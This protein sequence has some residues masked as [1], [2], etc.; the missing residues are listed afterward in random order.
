MPGDVERFGNE[1]QNPLGHHLPAQ[2]LFGHRIGNQEIAARKAE[3]QRA[4]GRQPRGL[5]REPLLDR[6]ERGI[7]HRRAIGRV[8][9]GHAPEADQ[10]GVQRSLGRC[11]EACDAFVQIGH[12][13]AARHQLRA[14]QPQLQ[15]KRRIAERRDQ[16]VRE[17]RRS[18]L[19]QA[20]PVTV[21]DQQRRSPMA[22]DRVRQGI[23]L[24]AHVRDQQIGRRPPGRRETAFRQRRRQRGVRHDGAAAL[25]GR[26]VP[27][28]A[29]VQNPPPI[30][31]ECRA[32]AL[33]W[34]NAQRPKKHWRISTDPLRPCH[35]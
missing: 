8:D 35:P 26:P 9:C 10:H 19:V 32:C 2:P 4:A 29:A 24:P 21:A 20:W 3:R 18:G 34:H 11:G 31:P 22:G 1:A 27:K 25:P 16:R 30:R 15:P 33:Q 12:R 7:A 17:A 14:N 23:A 5:A 6:L 13:L 28:S